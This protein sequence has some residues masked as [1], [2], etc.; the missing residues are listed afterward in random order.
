MRHLQALC[1]D[2][3]KLSHFALSGTK[4]NCRRGISTPLD[5]LP[6]WGVGHL[7]SIHFQPLRG[8]HFFLIPHFSEG[9]MG[10][11]INYEFQITNYED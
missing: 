4:I 8:W 7:V 5:D 1:N 9:A 2:C 10:G 11:A 3:G 6:K